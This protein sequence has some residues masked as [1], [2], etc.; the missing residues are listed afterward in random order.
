MKSPS[1]VVAAGLV[2]ALSVPAAR[3]DIGINP[4]VG[5]LGYGIEISTE[6]SDKL[7]VGLGFNNLSRTRQDN[8]DGVDYQFDLKLRSFE[9][10]AN[11]HPFGGHFRLRGGLLLNRN[12]F[13]LTGQP[14]GGTY[15]FNGVIYPAAAV[16]SLTG[17]LSF[18][19]T[20][21]YLGL[22]WGNRPNGSWGVTFDLGAVYQGKPK[23][24]LEATKP[25]SQC[26]PRRRP[27]SRAPTSGA[28]LKQLQMVAGDTARDVFPL[29]GRHAARS[30]GAGAPVRLRGLIPVQAVAKHVRGGLVEG[31]RFAR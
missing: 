17:K 10:L 9:V 28:G 30:I 1:Y 29:L 2:L 19:K 5:T 7:N 8:T 3:A 21:P 13:D 20:A 11:Y 27:R 24:S 16:G 14:S 31:D 23:L 18:N 4:R 12:E 22:G 6:V 26:S 25:R 15:D